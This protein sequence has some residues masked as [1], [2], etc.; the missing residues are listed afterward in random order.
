VE[1]D[2]TPVLTVEDP[3][4]SDATTAG[5][6]QESHVVARLGSA[7]YAVD[8][9]VVAEVLPL[10]PTSRLPG[11]PLWLDGI[12]NWRGRVLPVLDLRPLLGAERRPAA[13]SA[14]LI[15]MRHDGVEA[16]VLVDAVLGLMTCEGELR[17]VPSTVP[18]AAASILSGTVE[19][20]GPIAVID[21]TSVLAL[22]G[23]LAQTRPSW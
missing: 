22:R 2:P 20:G 3:W 10:P 16:G 12:A 8:L 14:R 23:Q 13:S 15:V 5:R 4:S 9:A 11:A 6:E 21:A 18:P 17:E 7:R 1:H 19:D